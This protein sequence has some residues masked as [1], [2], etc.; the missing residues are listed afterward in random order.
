MVAAETFLAPGGIGGYVWSRPSIGTDAARIAL[1]ILDGERAENIP[2]VS[3]GVK[4]IFNW[5]Q[6]QRW[7]VSESSLPE[8]SEIRFR[9]PIFM[10]TISLAEH[11]HCS[12]PCC[13]RRA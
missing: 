11:G 4:P 5:Q 12:P 8:G 1:R 7:K 9:E 10:G 2:P 6:M 13:S 3:G